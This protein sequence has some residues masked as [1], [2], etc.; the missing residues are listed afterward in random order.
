MVAAWTKNMRRFKGVTTL[1]N[2]KNKSILV[3]F[4]YTSQKIE[5]KPDLY[6]PFQKKL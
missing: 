6:Y 5:K 1:I 4:A 3:S 2:K